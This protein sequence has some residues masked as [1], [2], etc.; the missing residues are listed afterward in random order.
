MVRKLL[1]PWVFM[2]VSI[3]YL[4]LT[5]FKLVLARDFATLLSWEAFNDAWFGNLWTFMGPRSKSEG[6]RWIE[7]LLQGRIK[8][9]S[10]IDGDAVASTPAI[11]GVVLEIGAGSGMWMSVLAKVARSAAVSKFGGL[12]KIYGVEPNPIS[13]ATLKRRV[14]EIGLEGS[15]EVLPVGIENLQREAS[16]EPGSIDC[17]MTV[18]CLCSI[19][20]P[21]KNIKLLY[22]YLKDGGRWYV[23]EHVKSDKGLAAPLIQ[24]FTNFF[25][26]FFMGSCHLCRPTRD[27]ILNSG[28][29][30][31]VDLTAR[32][33][34]TEFEMIPHIIGS[35]TKSS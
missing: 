7:P 12:R 33:D 35:L 26:E 22:H 4:S 2:S 18:Q 1:K 5:I 15:Y 16:V 29:W 25:W 6:E 31:S 8:D 3:F 10:I 20:E 13:A 14:S 27:W 30:D 21:E 28:S 11:H 24:R 23:Y 17:I 9:G 19:P 32:S 34:E